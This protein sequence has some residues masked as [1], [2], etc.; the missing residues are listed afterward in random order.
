MQDGKDA[1]KNEDSN[2]GAAHEDFLVVGEEAEAQHQAGMPD[3]TRLNTCIAWLIWRPDDKFSTTCRAKPRKP[4]LDMALQAIPR[5]G[6]AE[7]VG[8]GHAR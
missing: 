5:I 7:K 8:A 2:I 3:K 6:G 1:E 4:F